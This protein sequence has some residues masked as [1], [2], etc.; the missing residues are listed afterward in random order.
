MSSPE[1]P[2]AAGTDPS[3]TGLSKTRPSNTA[4]WRALAKELS[5][6]PLED[7]TGVELDRYASALFWLNEPWRSVEIRQ[8]AH[9]RWLDQGDEAMA[10]RSAWHIFYE[11]WL[12][13]EAAVAQGWLARARRLVNDPESAVAG[14]IALAECDVAAASGRADE[15]LANADRAC[16]IGRA[17]GDPDLLAMGLQAEG[18]RLVADGDTDDGLAR[19]DEAM[20]AVIGNE[21]GPL[22][23]GWIYCNVISTCHEVGDLRRANEWSE[24]ALRWC[25]HLRD[26]LLYPGL[27]RVYSAQLAQ[28]RGDWTEAE[29][30]ARQA[31]DELSAF[32]QRY[33]GAAYYVVGELCRLQGRTDEAERSYERSHE[34]GYDPQP[35]LA[36]LEAANGRVDDALEA[37]RATSGL[38]DGDD[39]GAGSD[40]TGLQRLLAVVD[41]ADRAGDQALLSTIAERTA[42]MPAGT[43]ANES[44]EAYALSIEG[45]AVT[46]LGD[47][48]TGIDLLRRAV[49]LFLDL[50]LPYEAACRR[51]VVARA[52][53]ALGDTL[54]AKMEREAAKTTF[55]KLGAVAPPEP[56]DSANR[57]VGLDA[58][59]SSLS[60]R[61]LEVLVEIAS[62]M[63]NR[64][65]AERL[66]LSPHTVARHLGNIYDKL[67]VR[68][69]TAA[70]AV[71]S[72]QGLIP[73]P[74]AAVTDSQD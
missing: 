42:K 31:C 27:C 16:R 9:Q 40:L 12:V 48:A 39:P 30:S 56:V 47:C 52:A 49:A 2:P 37:L 63:T 62:G 14:W 35:G 10:A 46:A 34:L 74:G 71:A 24:A 7:L 65:A 38:A 53:A 21:L 4:D 19:L 45:H 54:T 64:A 69:R 17:A 20:V 43:Q 22:Y 67:G 41:L 29:R 50:G 15:A 33:A 28:L 61:E 5:A 26:G 58:S 60:A 44:L 55:A 36:L 66:H 70:V 6:R 18:R 25:T 68:T 59:P 3:N 73:Q 13:G 51:L 32:D 1:S 72:A 57:A 11:H 23:T 8:V